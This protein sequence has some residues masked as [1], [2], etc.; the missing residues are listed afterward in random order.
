MRRLILVVA[1]AL[2]AGVARAQATDFLELVKTGTPAQV[3]SAIEAG[4]EV[5]ARDKNG[6]TALMRCKGWR[7]A[8]GL[9]PNA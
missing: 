7:S 8:K 4:A 6:W 3:Q 1:L 2:V 5:N 9:R